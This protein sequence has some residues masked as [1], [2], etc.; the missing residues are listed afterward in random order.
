MDDSHPLPDPGVGLETQSL[1]DEQQ[2]FVHSRE[3]WRLADIGNHLLSVSAT[4]ME[5][6]NEVER[7]TYASAFRY[8][9]DMTRAVEAENRKLGSAFE[10]DGL[11]RL[12]EA[13]R[14]STGRDQDPRKVYIHTLHMEFKDSDWQTGRR[15]KRA[16]DPNAPLAHVYSLSLWQAACLNFG[17]GDLFSS[18]RVRASW[19]DE[20]PGPGYQWGF[21]PHDILQV[22]TMP[23][24]DFV[25]IARAL[26]L[27]RDLK[28]R[29]D[30]ALG[31]GGV[32]G[33][34]L[35]QMAWAEIVF[36]PYEAYRN[37]ASSGVTHAPFTVLRH[38]LWSAPQTVTVN[39]VSIRL[40]DNEVVVILKKVNLSYQLGKA[41]FGESDVISSFLE[42]PLFTFEIERFDGVFSYYPN[43]L[44]GALR[45]HSDTSTFETEFKQQ[46]KDDNAQKRLNWFLAP[47]SIKQQAVVRDI[48]TEHPRPEGLNAVT[49]GLYDA[50]HWA[51]PAPVLEA[52][53]WNYQAL[54]STPAQALRD[55]YLQRD[56]QNLNELAVERS[57]Q[58]WRAF[59]EGAS[60]VLDEVLGLLLLPVP[61]GLR[62]MGRVVQIALFGTLG[63]NFIQGLTE[64]AKG[65]PEQLAQ[66]VVDIGNLLISAGLH[67]N[68]VKWSIRRHRELQRCLGAAHRIQVAGNH[69]LW[70]SRLDRYVSVKIGLLHG[71]SVR[72]PGVIE[73][74]GKRYGELR[75]DGERQA[76]ELAYDPVS[77]EYT[78]VHP[79]PGVYRP[80][81]N[82][83]P[84]LRH[85]QLALDNP[86]P[87]TLS[88]LGER[89]LPGGP[90]TS[91]EFARLNRIS[92]TTSQTLQQVWKGEPAPAALVDT[93]KRHNIDRA[94]QALSAPLVSR[95]PLPEDADR[96]LFSALT[97]LPDWPDDLAL[98][99]HD[100]QGA[101][102][103]AY[104]K[105]DSLAEHGR[106][107]S[108]RRLADGG[109]VDHGAPET[110][111]DHDLGPVGLILGLLPSDAALSPPLSPSQA[112]SS[113]VVI[114]RRRIVDLVT[115]ERP[116][117]FEALSRY[118]GRLKS[119]RPEL[120]PGLRKF[121]PV[122]RAPRSALFEKTLALHPDLSPAR[123]AEWLRSP[124]L[125]AAERAGL[126]T[127]GLLPEGSRHALAQAARS[128][129]LE[130]SL[131]GIYQRRSWNPST[132]AWAREGM[133]ALLW[134]KLG[135]TLEITEVRPGQTVA[136]VAA[137]P[138]ARRVVLNHHGQGRYGVFDTLSQSERPVPAGDDNFYKAFN[139]ALQ[140]DDQ[141]RLGINDVTADNVG[142]LRRDT[143][144]AL[145]DRRTDEGDIRPWNDS[146]DAYRQ[147]VDLPAELEPDPLGLY[148]WRD[149]T[150]LPLD[151]GLFEVNRNPLMDEWGMEHPRLP[152]A[153]RLE[154]EHNDAGAWWHEQEQPLEWEGLK[155]FRRLGDRA[156]SQSDEL[157][158][159]L[160][161]I[162]DVSEDQ[163]RKVHVT[164]S[165]APGL[166]MDTLQRVDSHV[167]VGDSLDRL[168][169]TG[170][171]DKVL[172]QAL[173]QL[174]DPERR[175]LFGESERDEAS[176]V[177]A[178]RDKNRED[179]QALKALLG[180]A[181]E[182][183]RAPAND[184][185]TAL[186]RRLF[187]G[188]PER[189]A[190]EIVE[191]ADDEQ[192]R[193]M[194]TGKLPLALGQEA[195]WWIQDVRLGRALEGFQVDSLI[196][197]DNDRLALRL[198]EHLPGWPTDLRI[199]IRETSASGVLLDGLGST[200]A[201]Q[202]ALIVKSA[203]GYAPGADLG[204]GLRPVSRNLIPSIMAALPAPVRR[205]LVPSGLASQLRRDLAGVAAGDRGR[206]K[207][208][209]GMRPEIPGF[210]PPQ[211]LAD[212]RVGYELSG[213]EGRHNRQLTRFR[214]L[215]SGYSY[216]EASRQLA[217]LGESFASRDG[218]IRQRVQELDA[219]RGDLKRWRQTRY[220]A[221]SRA[222]LYQFAK[223]IKQ[224][225]RRET[226]RA[227]A[228]S[229]GESG[230]L[231]SLDRLEVS[232]FPLFPRA[233]DFSHVTR[234]SMRSMKVEA[235]VFLDQFLRQFVS[236]QELDLSYNRLSDFPVLEGSMRELRRLKLAHN[237]IVFPQGGHQR[238]ASMSELVQLDLSDNPLWHSPD[239]TELYL[240]RKL[241]LR[242]TQIETLPDGIEQ[243]HQ[244]TFAN[245][246]NN[247]IRN[248]S[249]RVLAGFAAARPENVEPTAVALTHNPLSGNTRRR[250]QYFKLS[251]PDN[252]FGFDVP[253][254]E[255]LDLWLWEQSASRD[256]ALAEAWH[257][258]SAA[259]GE[260]FLLFFR[261][262]AKLPELYL[263]SKD[264][265]RENL[266]EHLQYVLSSAARS[267]ELR[268][269]LFDIVHYGGLGDSTA[270]EIFRRL[271][272]EAFYAF[273][274]RQTEVSE[275][276]RRVFVL[277]R[278]EFR[279][280]TLH[281]EVYRQNVQYPEERFRAY[282]SDLG[283]LHLPPLF[284]DDVVP[285]SVDP[286]AVESMRQ[287][288]LNAEAEQGLDSIL[289]SNRHWQAFLK[290]SHISEHDR[291]FGEFFDY[292]PLEGE[293]TQD[294]RDRGE[295]LQREY[296]KRCEN[297]LR[298]LT[299]QALPR[300]FRVNIDAG[301]D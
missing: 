199:E 276:E 123:A 283:E 31:E 159:H 157:A 184:P 80:V 135:M 14:E 213:G 251:H 218:V 185:S 182:R 72:E 148:R 69:T 180:N 45:Y 236:L 301:P 288:I 225:W 262:L 255:G 9:N 30:K 2:R 149:K 282:A 240:L 285:R 286:R 191:Q 53:Q 13:L 62:G 156:A 113:R 128:Q 82:F 223:R 296:L 67:R 165:R 3:S 173:E 147:P 176:R 231:L 221:E 26:D 177:Q 200:D 264:T 254:L 151:D 137:D 253:E 193:E 52:L 243:L 269:Q 132:D 15:S 50:F 21:A 25:N 179:A 217:L 58:D 101:L 281:N 219:L 107:V 152:G 125:T 164:R 274:R 10:Q 289:M 248:I 20:R 171:L 270:F 7:L 150:W 44:G 8:L 256:D 36:N 263:E 37:G 111:A 205:A 235:P 300:L 252:R 97:Q 76:F 273:A 64:A 279:Y 167:R 40:P 261:E 249:G 163:L 22:S 216:A 95:S 144:D 41:L 51:F 43:R 129:G 17:F 6:L 24:L 228:Q 278:G 232:R 114:L 188:L 145:T 222:H 195:R 267:P 299:R 56:R 196:N 244:L 55:Y 190:R 198:L 242:N 247:R 12:R 4:A 154:L 115:R 229:S 75:V 181:L 155:L 68:A 146:A 60:A 194:D 102:L 271:Q 42:L 119:E 210:V 131:D 49:G 11:K 207:R 227:P 27:G 120:A 298:I 110:I 258:L 54:T 121:L 280:F 32:L 94:L 61:G 158:R 130:Q 48:V 124:S 178:L 174:S 212:G 93:V 34:R 192:L 28:A 211:R 139:A 168:G 126:L 16:Y 88:Q 84:Q 133:A 47:L 1:I 245:L 134:Q 172:S 257:S 233:A 38:A 268:S 230:Y 83:D 29:V 81:V 66:S 141:I 18:E 239:L 79:D 175:A 169:T 63:Y 91:R 290:D 153:Y 166:L 96:A 189:V 250:L 46:L 143:G 122:A 78:L 77:K 85:W 272:L 5:P 238:L 109:Y 277:A 90:L 297:W 203:E 246:S 116:R 161:A 265:I 127:S 202:R 92:G 284:L 104:G 23:I 105:Q 59:I 234:L 108:I 98:S 220:N 241:D 260:E 206:A 118:P 74:G 106:R 224:C 19:I 160:M 99:I 237:R 39:A 266:I 208:L 291:L 294:Y 89:L 209:L 140:R 112:F 103:E 57:V 35:E 183:A 275:R 259:S 86:E 287:L 100:Q 136:P 292:E 73:R 87:P 201:S 142:L 186:I 170:K 138:A 117:L 214:N 215:Y 70:A 187:P 295:A 33:Q 197:G 65:R 71:E 226:L 162:C 293:T 204:N